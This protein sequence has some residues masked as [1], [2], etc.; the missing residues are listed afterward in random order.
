MIVSIELFKN[1]ELYIYLGPFTNFL[2]DCQCSCIVINTCQILFSLSFSLSLI[3]LKK[4][5]TNQIDSGLEIYLDFHY[6]ILELNGEQNKEGIKDQHFNSRD[7]I[8]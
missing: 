5:A 7:L 3:L 1:G 6:M 4:S 8:L 2:K